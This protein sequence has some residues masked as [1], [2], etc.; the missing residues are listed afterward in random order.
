MK[1]KI[2][3]LSLGLVSLG[4]SLDEYMPIA[5]KTLELD[6]GY[7]PIFG[8]GGYDSTGTK[9]SASGSPMTHNVPL[10]VKYAIMNG[11]DAELAFTFASQ[12]TDA[13]G[14]SG[15]LQPDIALKYA[16]PNMPFAAFVD[17]TLPFATGDYDVSGIPTG[18]AVGGVSGK[19]FDK[20]QA[21]AKV[22]YKYNLKTSGVKPQDLFDVFLK[23][24]YTISDALGAYLG[25]DYNMNTDGDATT[26]P[27]LI[28]LLPGVTYTQNKT[29]AYEVN[30][31][32][33]VAGQSNGAYWGVWASV[34][35]TLG[36]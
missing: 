1:M 28:S 17:V 34:Y 15:F 33:T 16:L 6:G 31:P 3:L 12:N 27:Y 2:A 11:L 4:F 20:I 14:A 5:P 18:I 36:M 29:L 22:M 8:T 26:S 35:V 13:G 25:I 24:G 30:V 9:G 21:T 32:L 7:S 23:P 10:Q 19:T